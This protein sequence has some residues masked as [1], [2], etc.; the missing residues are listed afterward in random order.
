[1]LRAGNPA[2]VPHT[3]LRDQLHAAKPAAGGAYGRPVLMP[4]AD[5][6]Q[7]PRVEPEY[8]HP[9]RLM[10][11]ARSPSADGAPGSG[12]LRSMRRVAPS[13]S[14]ANAGARTLTSNCMQFTASSLASPPTSLSLADSTTDATT[15]KVRDS[16]DS[17][18]STSPLSLATTDS[19]MSDDSDLSRS[20]NQGLALTPEYR[21][22][23]GG[24][25]PVT[26]PSVDSAS[27]WYMLA[28]DAHGPLD[29]ARSRSQKSQNNVQNL[30]RSGARVVHWH[31]QGTT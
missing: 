4:A 23:R 19:S 6:E 1:M 3:C 26:P 28:G 5:L 13:V 20:H 11:T 8:E 17:C 22:W 16:N 15:T 21:S 30:C 9:V 29:S 27:S 31:Y 10:K 2:A 14:A 18:L 12:R 24:S 25:T 7:V